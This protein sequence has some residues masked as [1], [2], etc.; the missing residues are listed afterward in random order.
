MVSRTVEVSITG[1]GRELIRMDGDVAHRL[2]RPESVFAVC[3]ARSRGLEHFSDGPLPRA[4]MRFCRR[5]WARTEVV[6][7]QNEVMKNEE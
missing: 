3:G 1:K 5:C 4:A 2:Y 6:R 7:A